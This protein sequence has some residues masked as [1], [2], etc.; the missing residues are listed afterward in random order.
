MGYYSTKIIGTLEIP[1]LFIPIGVNSNEC[2]QPE[3][4]LFFQF[5]MSFWSVLSKTLGDYMCCSPLC[6]RIYEN[7]K[8]IEFASWNCFFFWWGACG[9]LEEIAKLKE[10]PNQH[11]Y[12]GNLL[13]WLFFQSLPSLS[14]LPTNQ[15]YSSARKSCISVVLGLC[16]WLHDEW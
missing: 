1:D 6:W 10:K 13:L 15:L 3:V 8:Q 11:I 7:V 2:A 12:S 4:N 9:W 14:S 5:L 16:K